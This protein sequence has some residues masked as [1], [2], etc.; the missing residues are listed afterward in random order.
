MNWLKFLPF[1]I[2]AIFLGLILLN[3]TYASLQEHSLLPLINDVGKRFLLS[4]EQ[5]DK[6]SLMIVQNKGLL[7]STGS[8]FKDFF[9]NVYALLSLYSDFYVVYL[10]IWILYKIWGSINANSGAFLNILLSFVTFII[11]QVLALLLVQEGDKKQLIMIPFLAFLHFYQAI[12][13]ILNPIVEKLNGSD[14][15]ENNLSLSK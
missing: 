7:T 11:L 5:I 15:L 4:T 8:V 6:D 1:G 2:F 13:Y 10:W 14:L 12:P 3:A 9:Y